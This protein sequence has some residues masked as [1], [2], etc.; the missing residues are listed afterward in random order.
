MKK[1]LLWT[2]GVVLGLWFVLYVSLPG[3]DEMRHLGTLTVPQVPGLRVVLEQDQEFEQSNG[4]YYRMIDSADRTLYG[5]FVLFGF[6]DWIE[7][8]SDFQVTSYDGVVVI[9]FNSPQ[10]VV[11]LYDVRA[12]SGYP[13]W[14]AD[15]TETLEAE[16]RRRD[17]L[18]C[19]VQACNPRLRW[20]SR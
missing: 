19:R 3:P 15:T 2:M 4:V 20:Q 7:G 1:I 18:L 16:Y 13:G 5:P 14:S 8:T 11:A 9:T 17:E 12:H 6:M 10:A